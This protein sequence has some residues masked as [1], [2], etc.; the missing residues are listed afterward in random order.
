[1]NTATPIVFSLTEVITALIFISST[2]GWFVWHITSKYSSTVEKLNML[3]SDLQKH[4]KTDAA[5][6]SD[7]N[8]KIKDVESNILN[9]LVESNFFNREDHEKITKSLDNIVTKLESMNREVSK[10]EGILQQHL[11]QH[12]A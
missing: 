4:E 12:T 11:R 9:K 3:E 7:L 6:I 10:N 2:I 1:M 8:L 5:V